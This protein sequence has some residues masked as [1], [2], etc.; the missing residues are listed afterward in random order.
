MTTDGFLDA[1]T[2]LDLTSA[3][4]YHSHFP[5]S[6]LLMGERLSKWLVEMN[7]RLQSQQR[8]TGGCSTLYLSAVEER[9]VLDVRDLSEI[10]DRSFDATV[11]FGGPILYAF[12]QAE[13]A[14]S[15]CLRVTQIGGVVLASVMATIGTMRFF[16]SVVVEE[17]RQYGRQT[18]SS[19]PVICGTRP[20]TPIAAECSAGA[21]SWP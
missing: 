4:L 14:L 11:A 18:R 5:R 19:A 9:R 6:R 16:L 13:R 3:R 2:C 10:P 20:P 8:G 12:E 15:E 21:K 17:S 1:V 7:A